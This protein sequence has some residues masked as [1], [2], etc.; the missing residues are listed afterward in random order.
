MELDQ[1]RQILFEDCGLDFKKLL[2]VGVSGGPDSLC[3]LDI[4]NKIGVPLLVAH[5]DHNLRP[6]VRNR[7][8][9]GSG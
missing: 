3:L 1:F 4:L 6:E 5:F 8:Q 9:A 7:S 2:V